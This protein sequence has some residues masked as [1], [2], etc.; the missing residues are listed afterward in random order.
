MKHIDKIICITRG[1]LFPALIASQKYN[2]KDIDTICVSSY[3][4]KEKNGI[5]IQS[6]DFS[7]IKN[8][9]IL[10]V[11]DISDTG[12]TFLSVIKELE[13]YNPK[14]IKTYSI[15]VKKESKF[16]PDFY[17]VKTDLK[18]WVYFQWEDKNINIKDYFTF[19]KSKT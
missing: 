2:I 5:A 19:I 13:K 14:S 4:E 17:D 10:I 1:G 18:D 15:V 16:I 6:K 8:K 3:N 7:H 9:N 11:D 12:E